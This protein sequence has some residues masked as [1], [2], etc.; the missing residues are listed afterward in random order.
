MNKAPLNNSKRFLIVDDESF[1]VEAV[2]LGLK[3]SGYG[4]VTIAFDGALALQA[5]ETARLPFDCVITDFIMPNMNG[6]EMLKAI[7][8]GSISAIPRETP[9]I[10][11]TSRSDAVLVGTALA[12]DASGFI[13]KPVSQKKLAD[14]VRQVLNEPPPIRPAIAYQ[15]ITALTME[16]VLREQAARAAEEKPAGGSTFPGTDLSQADVAGMVQK[17]FG[18]SGGPGVT[19]EQLSAAVDVRLEQVPEN[20]ILAK[21]IFSSSGAPLLRAGQRLTRSV[22]RRLSEIREIGEPLDQISVV[23]G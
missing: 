18:G 15:V 3:N 8:T 14:R 16:D 6:L 2:R 9:V 5:L 7:R 13:V 21:D 20:A 22:I 23:G 12:L 4:N 11:M 1:S 19:P 10:L 17:T